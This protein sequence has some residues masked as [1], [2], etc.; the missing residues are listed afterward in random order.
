MRNRYLFVVVTM[1]AVGLIFTGCDLFE[2]AG[3]TTEEKYEKLIIR[4]TAEGG[5]AERKEVRTEFST[6]RTIQKV[7]MTPQTNDSY[8]IY[9]DNNRV[10]SG[11]I[12]V[13]GNTAV[14]TIRFI[15]SSGNQFNATLDTDKSSLTFPI[16]IPLSTGTIMGYIN[17]GS[18]PG[19]PPEFETDLNNT[20]VITLDAGQSLTLTV[21][22]K[23]NSGGA[24]YYQ[25]YKSTQNSY[26]GT[27]I[28]NETSA[29]YS[30]PTTTGGTFFYYVKIGNANGGALSSKIKEVKVNTMEIVVGNASG[31]TPFYSLKDAIMTLLG[32]NDKSTTAYTVNFAMDLPYPLLVDR[33]AF[34]GTGKLTIK[35]SVP[36]TK[37]IYITRS[38]VELNGL[39]I[40]INDI[41]NAAKYHYKEPCA[42]LVSDIYYL[43][44]LHTPN[45][46]TY[47]DYKEYPLST[48]ATKRVSIVNCKI[49]LSVS[50]DNDITGICVDPFT[51]GRTTGTSDTRVKIA[52]T[53]VGVY[54]TNEEKAQCF[55]GDNTDF[56]NNTFA[57]TGKA[58]V[59]PFLLKLTYGELSSTNTVSFSN[60]KFTSTA[61]NSKVFEVYVNVAAR[62]YGYDTDP[63][64]SRTTLEEIKA[65]CDTF[66]SPNHKFGELASKY[67]RFI[68]ILFDQIPDPA[69]KELLLV[70][71]YNQTFYPQV[72]YKMDSRDGIIMRP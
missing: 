7:I 10:S 28:A 43:A 1:L 27:A 26:T 23:T 40:T 22:A 42:V 63:T 8:E 2:P 20:S 51:A 50:Y 11:T 13:T 33:E 37:G 48:I 39:N 19:V 49:V 6:T 41:G 55:W 64:F 52:G 38:D 34:P 62:I 32:N 5:T 72:F 16:G 46:V 61:S 58:A 71:C 57:S 70:D 4:G 17:E 45:L 68:E 59:F 14:S 31:M 25:W 36:F 56:S 54:N 65:T 60:N 18:T 66:G 24:P 44:S 47:K 29:S 35:S 53:S 12:S 3:E 9:Y 21:S 67:R 30:V 15:P 69:G